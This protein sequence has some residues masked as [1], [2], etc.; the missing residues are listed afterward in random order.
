MMCGNKKASDIMRNFVAGCIMA[1]AAAGMLA[2]CAEKQDFDENDAMH[3]EVA[4]IS[5]DM[6]KVRD[7]VPLYAVVAHRGTTYW[8]PEETEAAWRWAR[9]MG[10]DYLE[11]DLQ[12]SK[13]GVVLANHDESLERTT[14]IGDVYADHIPATRSDFYRSFRNADGTQHF[15][16][17]DIEAQCRRDEADFVAYRTKSYYYHELL[18]LDAG[19]WFN[20]ASPEQARPSFAAVG[21]THLYVSALQDQMAYA[22]GKM[23][24]RDG[25]GERVLTYRIKDKY[26]DMTLAQIYN[27]EKK[28]VKCDNS[29]MAYSY[30]PEYMDFVE[31]DFANA[32]VD[33]PQDTGN[34]PG[35]YIEFKK[36]E[37]N[38]GDME[39][40][41]YNL[42]D[43]NGWNIVTKPE[44]G[45]AFYFG[46]KVNVGNT[47]GKVVM[48]TFSKD[49]LA[50]VHDVFEGK[51]PMCYLLWKKNDPTGVKHETAEGYA[52]IIKEGLDNGAHIIGPSISGEPNNY[53]NLNSPW[54]AC[55]IR[56]S[57]M[58]NHPFT[59]D[60]EEQMTTYTGRSATDETGEYGKILNVTVPPTAHSVSTTAVSSQVRL[61]GLFTNLPGMSLRYLIEN[62]YR[63]NANIP[64]P[65]HD[66]QVYD[67]SDASS[68]VPDAG[69]TLQRLGY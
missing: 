67:N 30:A 53:Y 33:D 20:A 26:K 6:A 35:I 12:S 45:N 54:Q 16:E 65:F 3:I 55:L 48:Q 25:N 11:S 24:K 36:P 34:R 52:S 62:G 23:L 2:S 28:T 37:V 21:G 17:D 51:V 61:D 19:S 1:T 40:R 22:R 29:G 66:G 60:S 69:E 57:G 41:V 47:N 58:L 8:A 31:Y 27:A 59:F 39:V 9:E 42:L 49:A 13:D 56:R 44:A 15:S 5:A 10:A 14:N 46:G 4:H 38:P 64:N 68:V 32:Y 43:E 18:A 50:K 7:Y 63:C